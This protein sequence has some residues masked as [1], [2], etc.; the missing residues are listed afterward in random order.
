[1][2]DNYI[3]L[4]VCSIDSNEMFNE[5]CELVYRLCIFVSF[6]NVLI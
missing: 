5:I 6:F 2:F 1:M 4:Y 3:K